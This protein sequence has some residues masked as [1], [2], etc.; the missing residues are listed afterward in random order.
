MTNH[1]VEA[2]KSHFDKVTQD[3]R[4]EL[5][6][7]VTR[8]RGELQDQIS[9]FR[10][11]ADFTMNGLRE[12]T[13]GLRSHTSFR[14]DALTSEVRIRC[15]D[16][17]AEVR[18]LRESNDDLRR[19]LETLEMRDYDRASAS[20]VPTPSERHDCCEVKGTLTTTTSP[21]L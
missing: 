19:Q 18:R 3:F 5:R 9:F 7:E 13:A 21:R 8:V 16:L 6:G 1:E 14:L 17:R 12:E 2:V 11:G 10:K 15:G 4:T 20:P